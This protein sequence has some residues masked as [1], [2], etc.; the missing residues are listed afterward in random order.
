MHRLLIAAAVLGLSSSLA[1]ANGADRHKTRASVHRVVKEHLLVLPPC[2]Q[3]NP[4]VLLG[5]A[6]QVVSYDPALLVFQ[7]AAVKRHPTPYPRLSAWPRNY[8]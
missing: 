2:Y 7:K 8:Y 4:P 6:P 5:C 3:V 1:L